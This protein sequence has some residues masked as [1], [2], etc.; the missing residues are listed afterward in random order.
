[1]NIRDLD[2]NLLVVFHA[3]LEHRSVTRAAEAIGLS[4]PAMSAA[5]AR[6]RALFEDP[7]FVKAGTEMKPTARALELADSVRL[8]VDTIHDEILQRSGFDPAASRRT[9]TIV[10][11]DIG[12]MN[13]LP[14][15][16]PRLS[17]LAPH[18]R[19]HATAR[20]RL[21][22]ADA[23]ESGS[24]QL[25]VGYFPDLTSA[26]FYQQKLFENR[27]VCI[28]R[29]GHPQ[30]GE[31]LTLQQ[32]L[33]L[34]HAIVR[35]YGREHVFDQFVEQQG[36]ER[37]VAVELSNFMS[38]LP[39]IESSDLVAT[40]PADLGALCVRYGTIRTV[41]APIDAPP[42]PVHQFW[43]RRF[44]R[45]PANVWLRGVVYGLFSGLANAS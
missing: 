45:D 29:T 9:F 40:V 22:T 14:R 33:G 35:P 7:L 6:L 4:Q 31:R 41:D 10:T 34:S 8:I 16:L 20:P 25:A 15:L 39:I 24:A 18:V 2:L 26:G 42:V 37:K 38:L 21:A 17:E 12:E 43:H 28:V 44:H 3:M 19:I 11:P 27:H 23:L 36:L 30:V 32:Y 1:M 5:V 13:F